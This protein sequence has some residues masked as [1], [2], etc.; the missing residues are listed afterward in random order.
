MGDGDAVKTASH[1]VTAMILAAAIR[2]GY[3]NTSLA[4]QLRHTHTSAQSALEAVSS[5]KDISHLR[6]RTDS[7][8]QY[9]SRKFKKSMQ[10]LGIRHEFI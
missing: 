7:G 1:I 4:L 5:V 2:E 9:G 8:T 10:T 3:H 6:L